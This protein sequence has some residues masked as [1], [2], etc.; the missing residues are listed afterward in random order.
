MT[1]IAVAPPPDL[2]RRRRPE[3]CERD[4][5]RELMAQ[6]HR[7][8]DLRTREEL[9]VRFMP[10]A[11]ELAMRYSYTDE[12]VEDLVQ[13][14][15]LGLLK[16]IDRF[17]PG[18]GTKFTS[19]AIPTILGELK[20]HFRDKG[21]ALHVPRDLQERTLKVTR[22]TE[23]LSK[24]LGRSPKLREVA[25]ALGLSVEQVLEAHEA[26]GSYEAASLDAPV[27]HDDGAASLI[28]LI[29]DEDNGFDLVEGR[30]ALLAAWKTLPEVERTVLSLR[31]V[32]DLTQREI[33]ER[34]GFSQ[35]HVSRL[36]RRALVRLEETTRSAAAA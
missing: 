30:E 24:R 27:A 32:S 26:A 12:P 16:A 4:A 5:E 8:G 35:M 18:R 1:A 7:S 25:A 9:V 36:L 14:A 11:R 34:I 22:E 31:F 15:A 21:W 33:G 13:V 19:Y 17:E 10:L 29:G 6:Y 2:R 28:D 20:R 3:R 23:M